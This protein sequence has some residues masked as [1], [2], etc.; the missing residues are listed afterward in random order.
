MSLK[1]KI[2][3]GLAKTIDGVSHGIERASPYVE[4]ATPH[5]KKAAVTSLRIWAEHNAERVLSSTSA[6]EER[7]ANAVKALNAAKNLEQRINEQEAER[8]RK[9]REQNM[10]SE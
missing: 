5:V 2:L 3:G 8:K 10:K 9:E 1:D 4:K 7:Q 6:S